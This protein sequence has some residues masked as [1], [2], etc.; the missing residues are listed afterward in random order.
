M[1]QDLREYL[2]NETNRC[3]NQIVQRYNPQRIIVET[4]EFR[5]GGLSRRM[6]RFLSNM[7]LSTVYAKLYALTEELGIEIVDVNPAYTSQ[8]CH[9]CGFVSRLNRKTQGKFTCLF[10][11]CECNAD[12]NGSR[13]VRK[14]GSL[15]STQNCYKGTTKESVQKLRITEFLKSYV[16]ATSPPALPRSSSGA[17]YRSIANWLLGN[18]FPERSLYQKLLLGLVCVHASP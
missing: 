18:S 15:C 1:W 16:S 2:K 9:R 14:R 6:N 12:V 13:T 3:I 5:Y 10:C 7:G 11:G 4:L 8:E 17:R